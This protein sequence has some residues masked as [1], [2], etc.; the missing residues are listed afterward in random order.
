MT[1]AEQKY[2]FMIDPANL[3]KYKKNEDGNDVV[4]KNDPIRP[5]WDFILDNPNVTLFLILSHILVAYLTSSYI[6]T[7]CKDA[8]NQCASFFESKINLDKLNEK[9]K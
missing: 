8:A 2:R 9:E 4:N 1:E 3:Q 5:L 7:K 6:F